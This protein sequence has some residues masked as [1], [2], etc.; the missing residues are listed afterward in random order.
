MNSGHCV[1]IFEIVEED[2]RKWVDDFKSEVYYNSEN[3]I[4][5]SQYHFSKPH[6]VVVKDK[7]SSVGVCYGYISF[8][9]LELKDLFGSVGFKCPIRQVIR[10][11]DGKEIVIQEGIDVTP[12]REQCTWTDNTRDYIKKVIA[13][14]NIEATELIS[15]ELKEDDFLLWLQKTANIIANTGYGSG[16]TGKVLN[17]LGKIIDKNSIEPTYHLDKS[18]KY[19]N[20]ETFFWGLNVRSNHKSRNHKLAKDEINRNIVDSWYG[21]NCDHVYIQEEETNYIKDLYLSEQFSNF[22]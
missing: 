19:I 15:K 21:F 10:D 4:V 9:E 8:K 22:V 2:G 20:L 7:K 1:V 16:N 17:V 12:S 5:S 6:I 13:A 14:A 18:I 11:K 3:L